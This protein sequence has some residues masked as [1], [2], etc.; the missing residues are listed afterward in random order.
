M[1]WMCLPML[2]WAQLACAA[3][4]Q[5]KIEDLAQQVAPLWQTMRPLCVMAVQADLQPGLQARLDYLDNQLLASN[6]IVRLVEK[7]G[8]NASSAWRSPVWALQEQLER[9]ALNPS[10]R[11]PLREYYFKLQTQTPGEYRAQLVADVQHMSEQLNMSLREQLWKSCHALGLSQLSP[12]QIEEVVAARWR[13]QSARV[14]KQLHDEL[15]AFYFYSFRSVENAELMVMANLSKQ[16]KPWVGSAKLAI[17]DYFASMRGQLVAYP[18]QA[19]GPASDG[20]LP[21]ARP[22]RPQPQL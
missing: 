16:L 14:Q 11:E 22:W 2:L 21:A 9:A 4:A 13:Q 3:S 20:T 18:V 1:R 15:S 5:Q 8:E 17:A 19:L 7:V 10:E 12:E 6:L